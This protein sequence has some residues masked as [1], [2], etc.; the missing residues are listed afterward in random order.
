MSRLTITEIAT[1]PAQSADA[2][3]MPLMIDGG[4]AVRKRQLWFETCGQLS[5]PGAAIR[6]E[7]SCLEADQIAVVPKSVMVDRIKAAVDVRT[8]PRLLLSRVV[9]RVW[10]SRSCKSQSVRHRTPNTNRRIKTHW[11]PT[12][13]AA[14]PWRRFLDKGPRRI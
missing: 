5:V 8:G 9:T 1:P 13:P 10:A 2:A 14:L 4:P 3:D 12:D 6:F 11:H 7:D